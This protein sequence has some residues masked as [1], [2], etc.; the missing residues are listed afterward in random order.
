MRLLN[1]RKS[2]CKCDRKMTAVPGLS[3]YY[4]LPDYVLLALLR[5]GSQTTKLSNWIVRIAVPIVPVP[6]NPHFNNKI[7]LSDLSQLFGVCTHPNNRFEFQLYQVVVV[8]KNT[9]CFSHSGSNLTPEPRLMVHLE[10][11][12]TNEQDLYQPRK[13]AVRKLN[14]PL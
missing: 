8:R 3:Q 12:S 5:G 6:S 13:N 10:W 2:D 9:S 1:I 11:S 14:L 7:H 4:V